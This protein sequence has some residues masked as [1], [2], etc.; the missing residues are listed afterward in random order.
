MTAAFMWRMVRD[1]QSVHLVLHHHMAA[2][3]NVEHRDWETATAAAHGG[4]GQARLAVLNATESLERQGY[5]LDAIYAITD[6]VGTRISGDLL[7]M[8]RYYRDGDNGGLVGVSYR[9][10]NKFYINGE[11]LT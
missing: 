5:A 4:T 9:I 11:L 1:R 8:S 3:I 6:P 2:R 7:S 10:I